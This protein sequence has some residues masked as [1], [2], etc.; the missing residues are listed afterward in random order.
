MVKCQLDLKS[1][2]KSAQVLDEVHDD[3]ALL[4]THALLEESKYDIGFNCGIRSQHEQNSRFASG[5]SKTT[6]S[7]HL[8]RVTKET[9][10]SKG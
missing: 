10:L 9:H 3:L 2:K 4:A 1:V 6:N 5:V 7:R 8:P